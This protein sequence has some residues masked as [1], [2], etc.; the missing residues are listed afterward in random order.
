MKKISISLLKT[1]KNC[2]EWNE[3]KIL[4]RAK[5][6][7]ILAEKIWWLP[8]SDYNP[9]ENEEWI[10]WD[11]DYDYTN[12]LITKMR[13][14]GDEIDTSNISDVYRKIN[15]SLYDLD[16]VSYLNKEN[17]AFSSNADDFREP[18]DISNG[19]DIYIETNLSSQ[20]K[21]N[22][23]IKLVKIYKLD[24]QDIQF[25]TK[26]KVVN[27]EFDISNQNTYSALKVGQLAYRLF[28]YLIE[29]DKISQ[30]EID[31][32]KD[33][34]YTKS[35]FN[36]TDYPIIADDRLAY[37]GNRGTTRFRQ[38][39]LLFKGSELY[40]TTQWFEVNREDLI[41]WYNNHLEESI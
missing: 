22:A 38:T 14:M 23:I 37:K 41:N 26:K 12:M 4:E 2:E 21:I 11:E 8:I 16:S 28:E 15:T 10:Y 17:E 35:I 1:L 36:R 13:F 7:Y 31:K 6:I 19:K 9:K 40:I 25:L 20:A 5:E 3:S 34:A 33:K 30:E 29:M 32:F 24:P 27:I 18:W 39:P